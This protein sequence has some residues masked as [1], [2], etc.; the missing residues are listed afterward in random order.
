MKK[1]ILKDLM[2][3]MDD[4]MVKPLREMKQVPV[5]AK[6]KEGLQKG[7][8]KAEELVKSEELSPELEESE[9]EE[10]N[11]DHPVVDSP[12]LSGEIEEAPSEESEE[13]DVLSLEEIN[14]KLEH[15]QKLKAQK[16]GM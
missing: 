4:E 7:L 8:D 5:I 6:D 10:S 2:K 15:L 3:S 9:E 12:A 13:A 1:M 14:K 16:L 11:E